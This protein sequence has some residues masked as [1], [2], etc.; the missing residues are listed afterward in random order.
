[1]CGKPSSTDV[2]LL[3]CLHQSLIASSKT[4]VSPCRAR[5]L[6]TELDFG[7]ALTGTTMT[8]EHTTRPQPHE[9]LLVGWAVGGLTRQRGDNE[10]QGTTRGQQDDRGGPRQEGGDHNDRVG[11]RQR[12]GEQHKDERGGPPR[13]GNTPPA[14][15]LTSDCSRG[16]PWV[17]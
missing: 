5:T 10:N 13:R 4:V 9:Q 14:P 6:S 3:S 15:S 8:T 7:V 17:E 16:G 1:M 2:L 11:P 12:E